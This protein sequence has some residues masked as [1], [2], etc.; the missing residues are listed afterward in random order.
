MKTILRAVPATFGLLLLAACSGPASSALTPADVAV[1][2]QLDSV[3]ASMTSSGDI[4][5]PMSEMGTWPNGQPSEA[6]RGTVNRFRFV[7]TVYQ[8]VLSGTATADELSASIQDALSAYETICS[9]S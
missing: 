1:C 5:G 8:N 7:V 2:E 6:V 3:V 9:P 4:E